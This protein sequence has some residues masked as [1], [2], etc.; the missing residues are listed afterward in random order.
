MVLV[1]D[2]TERKAAEERMR[3][4]ATLLDMAADAI[5]VKDAEARVIN[6]NRGAEQLYGWDSRRNGRPANGVKSAQSKTR[7]ISI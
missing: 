2:L 3:D 5:I 4:Q 7:P 1:E 6:W